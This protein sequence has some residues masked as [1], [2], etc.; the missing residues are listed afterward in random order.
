MARGLSYCYSNSRG[1]LNLISVCWI[2]RV[3]LPL[4]LHKRKE[5]NSSKRNYGGARNDMP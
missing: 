4:R 1:L 2:S 3:D 5:R